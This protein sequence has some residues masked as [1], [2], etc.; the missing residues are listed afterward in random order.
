MTACFIEGR[1]SGGVYFTS[2]L[3]SRA[4]EASTAAIGVLFFGS[5]IPRLITASPRS[6][7]KRASSFSAKVG[8]SA[9]SLANLL[10]FIESPCNKGRSSSRPRRNER[11]GRRS[12]HDK[13]KIWSGSNSDQI[14]SLNR[15]KRH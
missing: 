14:C 10:S 4:A 7:N 13:N 3:V 11:R 5:P 9:I 12:E 8:D 2:P 6:R 1:P 15:P